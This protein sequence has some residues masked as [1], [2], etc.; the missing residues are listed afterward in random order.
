M[1]NFNVYAKLDA[2]SKQ[3][4]ERHLASLF[5]GG[6]TRFDGFHA[7]MPGLTFDYSKQNITEDD[8]QA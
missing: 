1:K 2:L 6:A 8:K 5:E 4:K 7:S 3:A